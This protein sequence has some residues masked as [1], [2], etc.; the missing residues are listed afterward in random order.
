MYCPTPPLEILNEDDSVSSTGLKSR[1]KRMSNQDDVNLH[2]AVQSDLHVSVHR[3]RRQADGVG[4][5]INN[6]TIEIEI[7]FILDGIDG[8]F[9]YGA[10]GATYTNFNFFFF[11]K[12]CS[13]IMKCNIS[14]I[15][16]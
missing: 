2:R 12:S 5:H 7:D 13:F 14:I 16:V 9:R 3:S 4:S 11:I 1:R 8:Y 6:G 10:I 15:Y